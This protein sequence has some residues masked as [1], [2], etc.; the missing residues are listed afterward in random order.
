MTN[1]GKYDILYSMIEI[2]RIDLDLW[3]SSHLVF[4]DDGPAHIGSK[5]RQFSVFDKAHRSLLGYVKWWTGYRQYGFF[6]LTSVISYTMMR[7]VAQ[8]C[9]EATA[10]H[11]SKLPNVKR[12]VDMKKARRERR[13]AKLALTKQQKSGSIKESERQIEPVSESEKPMVEG[14]AA[15]GTLGDPNTDAPVVNESMYDFS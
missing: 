12:H 15:V 7:Q 8:F 6:Q 5:T 1:A 14:N 2:E 10:A 13:I 3:K 9:E 4:R 11:M